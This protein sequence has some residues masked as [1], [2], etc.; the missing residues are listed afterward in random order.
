[1]VCTNMKVAL[2]VLSREDTHLRHVQL[3]EKVRTPLINIFNI[4]IL[5]AA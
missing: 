5:K 1:M 2:S 4:N 3:R